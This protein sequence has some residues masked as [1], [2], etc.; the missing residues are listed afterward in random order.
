MLL[1]KVSTREYKS[2]AI[3]AFVVE[4]PFSASTISHQPAHFIAA[5]PSTPSS[6]QLKLNFTAPEIQEEDAAGRGTFSDWNRT[7]PSEVPTARDDRGRNGSS[8]EVDLG[9]RSSTIKQER[10]SASN[11]EGETVTEVNGA[12]AHALCFRLQLVAAC[13]SPDSSVLDSKRTW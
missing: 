6:C 12:I 8:N 3:C 11:D 5:E 9:Q 10:A 2:D 1:V 7:A 13:S 4:R